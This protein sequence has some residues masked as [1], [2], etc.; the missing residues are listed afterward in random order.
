MITYP[1]NI[2]YALCLVFILLFSNCVK[3]LLEE[4]VSISNLSLIDASTVEI[5]PDLDV[6]GDSETIN[7]IAVNH[8]NDTLTLEGFSELPLLVTDLPLGYVYTFHLQ[9]QRDDKR[10]TQR[11]EFGPPSLPVLASNNADSDLDRIDMIQQINEVRQTQQTC[12]SEILPAAA[13]LIWNDLLENASELH[14]KDM[15]ANNF[16]E[17]TNPVTGV[18]VFDQV[19]MVNYSYANISAQLGQRYSSP[20]AAVEGWM[21]VEPICKALMNADFKEFGTFKHGDYWTQLIAL[22]KN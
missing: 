14:S 10:K 15:A 22:P 2:N 4:E 3:E 16:F 19:R 13:P 18:S 7:V 21:E 20:K 8:L 12:G 5:D 9:L 11:S 6:L 17:G 1:K